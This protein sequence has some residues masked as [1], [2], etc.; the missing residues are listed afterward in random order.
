MPAN[1]SL[2]LVSHTW[3]KEKRKKKED[4]EGR[5]GVEGGGGPLALSSAPSVSPLTPSFSPP[6]VSIPPFPLPLPLPLSIFPSSP[7]LLPLH[8]VFSS[9]GL[10]LK[11]GEA[12]QRAVAATFP[13]VALSGIMYGGYISCVTYG[14]YAVGQMMGQ[15]ESDRLLMDSARLGWRLFVGLPLIP[16]TLVAS[17]FRGFDLLLPFV[18]FVV[19]PGGSLHFTWPPSN[20]AI[21]AL[22]PWV[23]LPPSPL[24][25][26]WRLIVFSLGTG[27][28]HAQSLSSGTL[29]DA[30]GLV[31]DPGPRK[32]QQLLIPG[33]AATPCWR[34]CRPKPGTA[35][36]R[37]TGAAADISGCGED[38]ESGPHRRW[39]P[40][41]SRDLFSCWLLLFGRCHSPHLQEERCWWD[42]VHRR[43]GHPHHDVPLLPPQ[44]PVAEENQGL[45][46]DRSSG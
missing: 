16:V 42:P 43:A 28:H 19:L 36:G 45:F 30:G 32:P 18:P 35:A 21:V 9:S 11:A 24:H 41:A 8:T 46:R 25:C 17:C 33:A 23:T 40:V 4:G 38:Q 7:S 26:W 13:Y 6:L 27:P 37:P 14:F 15:E 20:S 34:E 10:F 12:I 2:H 39:G 31:L 22:L 5:G 29:K 3:E 1:G 44:T